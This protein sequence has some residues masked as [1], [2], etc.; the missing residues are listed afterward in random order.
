MS[1]KKRVQTAVRACVRSTKG[2]LSQHK[3][4]ECVAQKLDGNN[5][6]IRDDATHAEASRQIFRAVRTHGKKTASP[7]AIR[8]RRGR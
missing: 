8:E 2:E 7:R 4:Y 6:S 5:V 1:L 3:V